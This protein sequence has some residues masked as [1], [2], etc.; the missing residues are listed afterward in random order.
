VFGR[1][2]GKQVVCMQG[3]F[4]AYE[5][6]PLMKCAFPVRVMRLLGAKVAI[7]TNAAGGL[8]P[9]FKVGSWI[10]RAI[11]GVRHGESKGVED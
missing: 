9:D 7:I 6:Y 2:G 11:I 4:H 3:R 8:N 1:L 10:G 5:G